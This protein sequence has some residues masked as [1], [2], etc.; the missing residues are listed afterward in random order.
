MTKDEVRKRLLSLTGAASGDSSESFGIGFSESGPNHNLRPLTQILGAI[1]E[2]ESNGTRE[3]SSDASQTSEESETARVLGEQ[4]SQLTAQ[5]RELRQTNER[6]TQ[7]MQ[8][9]A[10]TSTSSSSDSSNAIAEGFKNLFGGIGSTLTLSPVIRGLAK[11]FGGGSPSEP[12]SLPPYL[13]PAPIRVEGAVR[14]DGTTGLDEVSYG[15]MGT[16]RRSGSEFGRSMPAITINVQA[17]DSRSFM[18]HSESIAEAVRDAMLH[19]HS[20]NDVIAEL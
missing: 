17:I 12:P 19:M 9:G 18:D 7:A 8:G 6:Q 11:L 2:V 13:A 14:R 16:P 1:S 3:S 5:T 20:L 10:R 15:L 4:L